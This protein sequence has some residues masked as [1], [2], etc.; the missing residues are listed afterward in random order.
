MRGRQR[1][2]QRSRL[3]AWEVAVFRDSAL[4]SPEYRN[5]LGEKEAHDLV[6][7]IWAD[8]GM[9]AETLTRAPRVRIMNN[10]GRGCFDFGRW[11]ILLSGQYEPTRSAW[12]ILH[13]TAHAIIHA[14][15]GTYLAPHG[16]EFCAVYASLLGR[17]TNVSRGT[18]AHAMRGARIKV[19]GRG[20]TA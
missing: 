1:D 10:R 16:P 18:I 17:Y 12:Y 13:E 6:A 5:A 11:M 9:G 19:D 4:L 8:W 20:V 3:Y 7:K 15:G 14:R 2:S